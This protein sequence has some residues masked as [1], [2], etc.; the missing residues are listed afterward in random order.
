MK[1]GRFLTL[2][3]CPYG[4]ITIMLLL[5]LLSESVPALDS[6]VVI[7][8]VMGIFLLLPGILSLCYLPAVF[9]ASP[10][11]LAQRN[12][13]MKL[14][15]LPVVLTAVGILTVSVISTNRAA[16]EGAKEG[17]LAVFLWVLLLLPVIVHSLC[18]LWTAAI[19]AARISAVSEKRLSPVLVL[20]HWVPAAA[21]VAAL[22]VFR[23][24]RQEE[25]VS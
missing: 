19:T 2:C 8:V 10:A 24:F 14:W 7:F 1:K 23:E 11:L 21:F 9:S 20:L 13:Q 3:L 15:N 12:L 25:A 16:A 6:D 5:F 17:G 4:Y 22:R 18:L